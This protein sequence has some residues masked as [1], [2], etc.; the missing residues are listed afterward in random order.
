MSTTS[1]LVVLG[2][3]S[4][5]G[6]LTAAL[7]PSDTA[8]VE[9]MP[10]KDIINVGSA[11]LLL[12]ALIVFLRFLGEERKEHNA[13]RQANREHVQ[14][15]VDRFATSSEKVAEEFNKTTA[16]LLQQARE[17]QLQ[18]RRELQDI[19]RDRKQP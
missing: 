8:A 15:V 1:T 12:A 18:A 4:A 11:G 16:A 10:L 9:A 19:I 2:S 7:L 17:D 3:L 5:G 13:D 6:F 14:R